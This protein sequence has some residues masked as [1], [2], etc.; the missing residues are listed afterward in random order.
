MRLFLTFTLFFVLICSGCKET[1]NVSTDVT[2]T[3]EFYK[4]NETERN[5][6]LN[7]CRNNPGELSE[8]PNCKNAEQ[9]ALEDIMGDPNKYRLK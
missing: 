2:R 3:V 9:A 5:N 1:E 8:T 7:E 4:Q 6:K